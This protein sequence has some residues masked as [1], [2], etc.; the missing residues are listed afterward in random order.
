MTMGHSDSNPLRNA[1]PAEDAS[2]API[3][4]VRVW[5]DMSYLEPGEPDAIDGHEA[6]VHGAPARA[7]SSDPTGP[8]LY[9]H[10]GSLTQSL[11]EALRELTVQEASAADRVSYDNAVH[12]AQTLEQQLA[13]LLAATRTRETN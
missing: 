3:P 7:A 12:L 2:R 6:Q 9:R 11:H 13:R 1:R 4:E 5:G 10:L 8:D